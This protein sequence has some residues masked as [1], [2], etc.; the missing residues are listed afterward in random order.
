MTDRPIL[1]SAPMVRALLAGTKMQTRRILK[2][3]PRQWEAQVID[4]T[5]PSFVEE[6]GGWGQ[7]MTTWGW[8]DGIY[9][10]EREI[11]Q[12]L[13]LRWAVGDRLWVREAFSYDGLDV[14]RDGIL[15]PWY[16]ADGNPERGD[17]TKPKPSIHMPRWA[18]RMTLT[19]T[20]IR[21][22]RLND[23]SEGDARAEGIT[24]GGC[25]NCGEP[26]PCAC[27]S[28]SPDARDSFA[29]LWNQI[30]GQDAWQINPWVVA[31]TFSVKST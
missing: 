26:E 3:Q 20:D 29:A 15:P 30:N 27:S 24:D 8:R 17:W 7:V 25:L 31:L 16:W 21:V 10:P 2:P 4:I 28:P 13:K 18:S 9:Q 5:S 6:E 19:I 1:F 14:D 23:I 11:W 12:P 22:Q